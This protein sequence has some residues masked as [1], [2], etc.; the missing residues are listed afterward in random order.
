MGLG[1]R[2]SGRGFSVKGLSFRGWGLEF[3][4]KHRLLR[5]EGGGE[6]LNPKPQTHTPKEGGRDLHTSRFVQRTQKFARKEEG[7]EGG[8]GPPAV[9]WY[10]R[11]PKVVHHI[12][13]GLA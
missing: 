7:E 6:T 12:L 5:E 10:K 11:D 2:V 4:V 1:F 3:R 13:P 9:R 8:G